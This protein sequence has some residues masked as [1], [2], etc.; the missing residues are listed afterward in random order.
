M[1]FVKPCK[2]YN[3]HFIY[4]IPDY[5]LDERKRRKIMEDL[6]FPFRKKIRLPEDID[7]EEVSSV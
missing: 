5:Y 1:I 6:G 3:L 2:K 4:R 7:N